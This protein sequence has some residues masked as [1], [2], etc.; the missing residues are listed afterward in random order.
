LAVFPR[1]S[2]HSS[3]QVHVSL[4][5]PFHLKHGRT[6]CAV[7]VSTTNPCARWPP[8]TVC[9]TR[10]SGVFFVLLARKEQDKP[11][12]SPLPVF[13]VAC[14]SCDHFCWNSLRHRLLSPSRSES[15]TCSSATSR[16]PLPLLRALSL[17]QEHACD[18]GP[19]V[20]EEYSRSGRK[21]HGSHLDRGREKATS[22]VT[23][24]F[25]SALCS[26]SRQ[27]CSS[28]PSP[29]HLCALLRAES[30]GWL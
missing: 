7:S 28:F 19:S 8:I 9:P 22:K 26:P 1:S 29:G 27:K 11:L 30:G 4:T 23:R 3:I 6:W 25:A 13:E 12:S 5:M 2:P 16:L 14:V 17:L 15:P 24:G 18:A 20:Q 10:R 21:E